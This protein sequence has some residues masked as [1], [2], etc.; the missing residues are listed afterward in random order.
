MGWSSGTDIAV[1]MIKVI[2]KNVPDLKARKKIYKV[3]LDS[4]EGQD[5][6]SSMDAEGIDLVFDSLLPK[7]EEED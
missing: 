3:L 1:E 4:L 6:D 7:Y 5:W 2:K